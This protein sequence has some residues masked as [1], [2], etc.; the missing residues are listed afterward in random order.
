[1]IK[2]Q[3]E[4]LDKIK[5]EREEVT[6]SVATYPFYEKNL[7]SFVLYLKKND[8]NT[9]AKCHID[10]LFPSSMYDCVSRRH[11]INLAIQSVERKRHVYISVREKITGHPYIYIDPGY[12]DFFGRLF[13]SLRWFSYNN[14]S[15]FCFVLV[16]NIIALLLTNFSYP[17]YYHIAGFFLFYIPRILKN[18][19]LYRIFKDYKVY[20][21]SEL[22]AVAKIKSDKRVLKTGLKCAP[23]V[24]LNPYRF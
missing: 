4:K 12:A 21:E 16:L 10:D 5:K 6:L 22:N 18:Y 9:V 3:R 20:S 24:T 17:I 2:S 1:M 19:K 15:F 8:R 14:E 23:I 11:A 13:Q 7:D